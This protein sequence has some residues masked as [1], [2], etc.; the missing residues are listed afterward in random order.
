MG[1]ETCNSFFK[2][3]LICLLL[4]FHE[5]FQVDTSPNVIK[6]FDLINQMSHVKRGMGSG[7]E[8]LLFGIFCCRQVHIKTVLEN[9]TALRQLHSSE[10]PTSFANINIANIVAQTIN[11]SLV[12]LNELTGLLLKNNITTIP[13]GIPKMQCMFKNELLALNKRTK[14]TKYF[15]S[16]KGP[17]D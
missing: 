4:L 15:T 5:P 3:P 17:R 2:V 9:F 7:L 11:A 12:S 10:L 13:V 1:N 8:I 14:N 16:S 6:V